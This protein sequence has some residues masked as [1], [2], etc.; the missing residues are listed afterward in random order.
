MNLLLG[1]SIENTSVIK[2]LFCLLMINL[3]SVVVPSCIKKGNGQYL[4]V[5]SLL[6]GGN[7]DTGV[8][9]RG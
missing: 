6:P 1:L 8:L 9:S 7:T 4:A 2:R 5:T 3:S